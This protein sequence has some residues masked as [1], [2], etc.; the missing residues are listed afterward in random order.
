MAGNSL[1][2]LSV[3]QKWRRIIIG[4][5]ILLLFGLLLVVQSQFQPET[6]M[7]EGLEMVGVVF[8]L[9]GI[10]GRLWSTLYIGGRKSAEVVN[11]GP[12]SITRNPLYLFS[13]LAAAGAGAQVGS[14]V[15][16]VLFFA[17]CAL[18]FHVVILREERFLAAN[19]GAD[20]SAY[21]QRVP[22]FFP[23]LSLYHEG[24]VHFQTKRL[25]M[26][27]LDGLVFL[28]AMPVFEAIEAAQVNG[29]LPVLLR[30]P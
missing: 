11:D 29:T 30:L 12:Y 23:K 17:L 5:L 27:L 18:V 10:V 6:A 20:Y 13:A 22:R 25:L 28:V 21:C 2:D 3:F 7:H 1:Q 14:L 19:F 16:T 4:A 8:M 9:L 26:T 15:T 24:T